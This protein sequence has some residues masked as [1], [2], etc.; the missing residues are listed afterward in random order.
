VRFRA[1]PLRSVRDYGRAVTATFTVP[2]QLT[3]ADLAVLE[4]IDEQALVD[5]LVGLVQV[6]SVTGTDAE[7]D[8]QQRHSTALSALGYEVDMWDLDLEGL[9]A[10]PG[11]PGTEAPRAE[12][13]VQIR[14]TGVDTNE[15]E[16][17][18]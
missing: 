18:P 16:P 15:N 4:A 6:P 13:Y 12:G 5:D 11:F 9:A 2:D 1:I 17:S 8:L 7:S 14:T 3:R 10:H